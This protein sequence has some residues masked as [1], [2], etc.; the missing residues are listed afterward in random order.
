LLDAVAAASEVPDS[1]AGYP[2]GLR[3]TQIPDPSVSSYFL[4]L[5]GRSERVTACACE[6]SGDVTLPQLLHL[7]NGQDVN[8]KLRSNEGRLGKLMGRKM[9]DAELIDEIFLATLSRP[10]RPAEALAA[11][12][13]LASG[14][15]RAD[16]FRDLFWA[17][18]N[19]KEFAFNH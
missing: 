17:L 1:F 9:S 13:A 11:E 10:P 7:H 18:L 5:F 6:R 2:V 12:S 4:G 19:S 8:Q 16:V 14:D 15:A 3:A